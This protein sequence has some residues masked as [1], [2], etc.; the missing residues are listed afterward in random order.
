L[1]SAAAAMGG[2]YRGKKEQKQFDI[3]HF[4]AVATAFGAHLIQQNYNPLRKH[5]ALSPIHPIHHYHAGSFA[6]QEIT[7]PEN[8]RRVGLRDVPKSVA[9]ANPLKDMWLH[10]DG[11]AIVAPGM[12]EELTNPRMVSRLNSLA[13]HLSRQGRLATLSLGIDWEAHS[14][15]SEKAMGSFAIRQTSDARGVDTTDYS[16]G[17]AQIKRALYDAG[18]IGDP[19]KPLFLFVGHFSRE[20]GN[21][22]L[23]KIVKEILVLKGQVVIM[24]WGINDLNHKDI[25]IY[26]FRERVKE[27]QCL[28]REVNNLKVYKTPEAQRDL[29]RDSGASKGNLLRGASDFLLVPS[30]NEAGPLVVLEAQAAGMLT[31]SSMKGGMKVVCH[32]LSTAGEEHFNA[33]DYGETTNSIVQAVNFFHSKQ[34]EPSIWNRMVRRIFSTQ[35]EP[36]SRNRTISRIFNESK[37]HDWLAVGGALEELER[38]Y[39][40]VVAPKSKEIKR[41]DFRLIKEYYSESTLYHSSKIILH[42]SLSE[43]CLK[44]SLLER[45]NI[46]AILRRSKRL[47]FRQLS[48]KLK[49]EII[50]REWYKVSIHSK[51][52][53]IRTDP[54]RNG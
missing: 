40:V 27:L 26:N 8:Y 19:V 21:D 24:G 4:H 30:Y 53:G 12:A 13:S 28:E 15:T 14:L 44:S 9:E 37:R 6:N 22:H 35:A 5:A 43:S 23:L 25:N 49:Y 54:L 20:L 50:F 10:S 46:K 3:V 47:D 34:A 42:L 31:I 48:L 17:K 36:S 41:E 52:K 11:V 18:L 29:F 38:F 16:T 51:C 45:L 1:N 2:L 7:T 33:L 32:P 39:G